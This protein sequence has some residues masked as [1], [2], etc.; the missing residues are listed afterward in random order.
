MSTPL[1]RSRAAAIPLSSPESNPTV[2]T[3][4]LA[5]SSPVMPSPTAIAPALEATP[6]H[7]AS[8]PSSSALAQ[9]KPKRKLRPAK[10]AGAPPAQLGFPFAHQRPYACGPKLCELCSKDRPPIGHKTTI[11]DFVVSALI[12]HAIITEI[13]PYSVALA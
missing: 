6:V 3:A 13:R 4:S 7:W 2:A 1:T 8:S 9:E 12:R 10:K 5:P 11:P